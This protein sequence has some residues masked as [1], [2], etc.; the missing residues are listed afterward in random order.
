MVMDPENKQQQTLDR[1]REA[2]AE[3]QTGNV[4]PTMTCYWLMKKNQ[5][6]ADR[7]W[8]DL[9]IALSWLTK[10]YQESPPFERAD[11]LQAYCGLDWKLEYATD[12]LPRGVDV[13]WVYYT[14]SKN[15]ISY[16]A[17]CCPNRFHPEIDCPLPPA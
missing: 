7:T 9:G 2:V 14:P 4:P 16:S 6:S 8:T 17:V 13:S 15:L 1:Y 10:Q 12:V 3:F 5:V 11:G